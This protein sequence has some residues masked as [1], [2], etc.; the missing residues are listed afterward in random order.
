VVSH[1]RCC[2]TGWARS[3]TR[4][5]A[6][7][8]GTTDAVGRGASASQGYLDLGPTAVRHMRLSQPGVPHMW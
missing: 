7:R 2:G 5:E 4:G 1:C 8:V 6:G 3:S